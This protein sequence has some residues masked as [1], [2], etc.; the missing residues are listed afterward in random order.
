M[1]II[2]DAALCST[3]GPSAVAI[4][5]FD[6]VHRGHR[7]L[8]AQLVQRE[9]E[10]LI[11]VVFSFSPSPESFFSGKQE[12]LLSTRLEK[13]RIFESLGVDVLI[14]YP[15][16]QKTADM[17][18]EVFVRDILVKRLHAVRVV[19]GEDLSFGKGG[20]GNF[21]LLNAMQKEC[22]FETVKVRKVE[23]GG[24]VISSSRIRHYVAAGQ[25]EEATKC[26][27]TPYM[28]IGM[29][30][31][32][33][34]IGRTIGIPTLNL[35]PEKEKLLPPFGVYYSRVHINGKSYF[36]MTNIGMKPTIKE[37]VKRVTVETYVYDFSDNVYGEDCVVELLTF[38][39]PEKKF[40]N[41]EALKAQMSK[42]IE[43]G[44]VY[45]GLEKK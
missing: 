44:R 23:E 35:L 40:E 18:P 9:E 2:T 25:M 43:D 38:R 28:V 17:A 19:A 42:D 45:H 15:F 26:L 37:S 31:H 7:E 36:G 8:L 22:G 29:V 14:E 10:N 13:R 34:A 1:Q 33:N 27:G 24:E 21:T 5:K 39:R 11:S 41:I 12:M 32:G 16:D 3:K 30:Q 4:G 6:G 20:K